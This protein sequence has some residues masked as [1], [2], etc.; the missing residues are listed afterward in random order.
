MATDRAISPTLPRTSVYRIILQ[1]GYGPD[2]DVESLPT[3]W[4]M[5]TYSLEEPFC[6]GSGLNW[7]SSP[8]TFLW[9]GWAWSSSGIVSGIPHTIGYVKHSALAGL[10]PGQGNSASDIN[11]LWRIWFLLTPQW[12]CPLSSLLLVSHFSWQI[13]QVLI[14][15]SEMQRHTCLLGIW[16][17][18]GRRVVLVLLVHEMREWYGCRFPLIK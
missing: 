10:S 13:I 1:L 14:S 18:W 4:G 17:G 8:H 15:T 11:F 3:Y 6:P 7:L 9:P 16:L 12:G 2:L 5:G